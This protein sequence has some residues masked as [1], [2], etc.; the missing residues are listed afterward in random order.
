MEVHAHTHTARKKWTHYLWEFLMLFLAVFCGFLAEN[1]REHLIEHA[2]EK[3][4]V[5]SLAE[6]LKKDTARLNYSIRRLKAHISAA[7]KLV[8][9]YVKD[10][11]DKDY[12]KNMAFYGREAG[13]SV[14]VVFSDRTSSQLKGTGSIRLIRKKDLVDS[15][16]QYWNNQLRIE[17]IHSRHE[18]S[19]M[20]QRK[21]GSKTFYWYPLSFIDDGR[22]EETFYQDSSIT[23]LHLEKIT[24]ICNPQLLVE[25]MN[26]TAI[27]YNIG[28]SQ[29]F[30]EL[31]QELLLAKNL[32]L[33]IKN[34]YH[35]E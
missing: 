15:L 6:D 13:K 11:K 31:E 33:L 3:V 18:S 19:R 32:I 16:Q 2:K 35:L 5:K 14:D 20:E 10:N 9:L 25:F 17:Q 29:Y 8:L 23:N 30:R 24:G 27:L 34:K 28:K 1:F 26:V 4:F 21:I 22:E 12:N 7:E